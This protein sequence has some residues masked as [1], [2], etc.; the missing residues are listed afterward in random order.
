MTLFSSTHL[1]F[2]FF[3]FVSVFVVYVSVSH[4]SLSFF[5][6]FSVFISVY[7]FFFFLFY[8]PLFFPVLFLIELFI[9]HGD[10]SQNERDAI[11]KSFRSGSI[12]FLITTSQVYKRFLPLHCIH[13]L[14]VIEASKF[15]L[16]KKK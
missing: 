7:D 9:K 14:L 11:L 13:T 1:T 8:P 4:F 12:R 2:F 15:Y 6:P 5:I 3:I 16:K 10:I